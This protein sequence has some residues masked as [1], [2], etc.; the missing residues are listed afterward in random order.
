MK[1]RL[2]SVLLTVCLL[3]SCA[4]TM[5]ACGE[6]D[7]SAKV[8]NLS[9]NPEIEFILDQNDKVV[10]VNALNEDGNHIISISIDTETAK[11]AFEGMTAEQAVELFLKITEENGY[12]ITGDQEEIEIEISGNANKLMRDVKDK[13]NEFFTEN[14]LNVKIETDKISKEDIVEEVEECLK[15]YSQKELNAMTEE[16]L[17]ELLKQSREETKNFLSQELKEAYY[18]IRYEEINIAELKEL[19][20]ILS[21]VQG[22]D[23]TAFEQGMNDVIAK[24]EEF[25]NAYNEQLL[26]PDSAYNKAKQSYVKA[27]ENLL[28]KR[29]ELE[30]NGLTEQ[31]KMLLDGYEKAVDS[32]ETALELAKTTAD[33]AIAIVRGGLNTLVSTVKATAETIKAF[34]ETMGVQMESIKVAEQQAKEEFK[35]YFAQHE[36]FSKYVGYAKSSWNKTEEP[37]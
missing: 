37:A 10:S 36:D 15:E 19:R 6:N 22:V 23:L 21:D 18:S 34:C 27:K 20:D 28:A 25:E 14:G 13:A 30:A 3:F 31:E 11:S 29:L 7:D 8:M 33:A 12:L 9:L 1:K 2:C 35:N 17:T 26:N 32:C 16:Q 4:F 5:S 24:V